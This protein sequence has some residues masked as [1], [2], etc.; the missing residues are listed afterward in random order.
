MKSTLRFCEGNPGFFATLRMTG[1]AHINKCLHFFICPYTRI[2]IPFCW[3]TG[4][5]VWRMR[6]MLQ[7]SCS[8]SQGT[9]VEPSKIGPQE[10]LFFFAGLFYVFTRTTPSRDISNQRAQCPS[11]NWKSLGNFM[12]TPNWHHYYH[13]L[14][15][16]SRLLSTWQWETISQCYH[17]DP[18]LYAFNSLDGTSKKFISYEEIIWKKSQKKLSSTM[19]FVSA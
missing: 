13:L 6:D 4:G 10:S 14:R 5:A 18:W 19:V 8:D 12:A 11:R 7:W 16:D 17:P 3:Y 15:D 9:W 1:Q 2:Y